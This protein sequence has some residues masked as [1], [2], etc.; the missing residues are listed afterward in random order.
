MCC[1]S[2]S[3]HGQDFALH[4]VV[5]VEEFVSQ[6]CGYNM[7]SISTKW[8]FIHRKILQ[9]N[10]LDLWICLA[11][12][13]FHRVH[14]S[15]SLLLYYSFI[16]PEF[17]MRG[18]RVI[19]WFQFWWTDGC[20]LPETAIQNNPDRPSSQSERMSETVPRSVDRHLVV[21][22]WHSSTFWS[23]NS[24]KITWHGYYNEHSHSHYFNLQ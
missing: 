15:W 3:S 17:V 12:N 23:R 5:H 13:L 18:V 1:T 8:S 24:E 6:S 10:A 19:Q 22:Y 14:T 11:I 16:T 2:Y 20:G 21:H 9:M 7:F 4:H